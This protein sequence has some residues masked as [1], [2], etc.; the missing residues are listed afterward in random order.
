MVFPR[1]CH[2]V[3]CCKAGPFVADLQ[4]SGLVAVESIV[5]K[6]VCD[7]LNVTLCRGR[8]NS[9]LRGCSSAGGAWQTGSREASEGRG[10][11]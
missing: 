2:G 8:S 6:G 1:G 10:A 3:C 7:G 11:N 9:G 5:S 4:W